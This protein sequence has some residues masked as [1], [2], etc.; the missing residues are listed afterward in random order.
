MQ[1][2]EKEYN[3]E[4]GLANLALLTLNHEAALMDRMNQYPDLVKVAATNLEPHVIAH[5]LRE[6]AADLH[7]YYQAGSDDANSRWIVDDKNTCDARLTLINAVK[8]VLV[9]GLDLLAV[10]APEKM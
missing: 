1:E 7:G 3:A 9:N 2:L 6:L 5:Y 10:N 8:Q 4:N